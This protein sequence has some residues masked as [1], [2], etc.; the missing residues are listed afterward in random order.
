MKS[1]TFLVKEDAVLLFG[2]LELGQDTVAGLVPVF[3][4]RRQAQAFAPPAMD[5]LHT[6]QFFHLGEL[7]R[8]R[9]LGQPEHTFGL[10]DGASDHDCVEDLH[11]LDRKTHR[12]SIQFLE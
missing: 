8:D 2:V 9:R 11:L 7:L 5:E 1:Q 3:S 12:I 4:S 6:Q 10:A